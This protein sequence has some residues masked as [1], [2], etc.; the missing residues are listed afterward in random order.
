[1]AIRQLCPLISA[2]LL[3]IAAPA[4]WAHSFPRRENPCAGQQL[5]TAPSQVTIDYD[6]PIERLFCS[7]KVLD[8]GGKNL[9]LGAPM[10][11]AGGYS[12]SVKLPTLKPGRYTVKWAVLCVDTHH[13]EGSYTFTVAGAR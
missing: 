13:T 6:A 3:L 2:A 4:A 11:G 7:L 8:A 1:M 9:A 5:Q 12:L 10:V